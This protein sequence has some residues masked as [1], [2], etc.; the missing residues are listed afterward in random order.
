MDRR[1]LLEGAEVR[2]SSDGRKIEGYAL[3]FDKLSEPLGTFRE[4]I[5]RDAVVEP[6]GDVIATFNHT[7]SNLLGR[8]KS[9][10][11]DLTI[12]SEGLRYV[13]DV[14][15]TQAGRDTLTL[16]ERGDVAGSSFTFDVETMPDGSRGDD[17][18]TVDGKTT[19]ILK[20][21]RV[22]E[23]GPVAYPAYKQ[24]SAEANS[25]PAFCADTTA[26]VR[27]LN[28][29]VREAR[30][31]FAGAQRRRQLLRDTELMLNED[32]LEILRNG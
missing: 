25:L 23:V 24:T 1:I 15:D 13:I 17:F 26:A 21:I 3:V 10:T 14:P 19:R 4:K 11:L 9:G 29:F 6:L 22:F 2:A 32:Q 12:D 27:S 5:N 18:K 28:E 16:V 30:G 31:D 8:T 7:M 20:R